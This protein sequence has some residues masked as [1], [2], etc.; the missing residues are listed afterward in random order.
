[1][2]LCGGEWH[3]NWTENLLFWRQKQFER[4]IQILLNKVFFSYKILLS[5]QMFY[6]S[7]TFVLFFLILF[8]MYFKLLT[9]ECKY[10]T[11]LL[12]NLPHNA[13][14]VGYLMKALSYRVPKSFQWKSG[15]TRTY[16]KSKS[17]SLGM[18]SPLHSTRFNFSVLVVAGNNP[19]CHAPKTEGRPRRSS[20]C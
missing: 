6:F 9:T 16:K 8:F 10:Y 12:L 13:D 14:Q 5:L 18:G 17:T 2:H 11:W 4:R 1:M 7:T 19:L 20:S 3:S 15:T